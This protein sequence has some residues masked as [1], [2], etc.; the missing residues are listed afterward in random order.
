MSILGGMSVLNKKSRKLV[1]V[2]S[3][4]LWRKALAHHRVAAALEHT[5]VLK[6]LGDIKTIIDIGANR[7]QFALVARECY[8]S[9]KVESFEPLADAVETYRALF[10]ADD[11]VTI[12]QAAIA[13]DKG[14]AT[15]HISRRDDSSSLLEISAAQTD[16]FPGTQEAGTRVVPVGPLSEYLEPEDIVEPAVL[17]LDVQGFEL[18][19]L[20]GCAVLLHRFVWIYVECSFVELYTNQSL[21]DEVISWLHGHEFALKGV[22]NM[23]YDKQGRAVQADFLFK[24]N[25]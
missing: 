15:I 25:N 20:S 9:A 12:H 23:S 24:R 10:S 21:A 4:P 3:V 2:L 14:E 16:L 7:G 19:A 18:Q 5:Q 11:A 1:G 6:G 13:P 8:P 17:K 22:Y